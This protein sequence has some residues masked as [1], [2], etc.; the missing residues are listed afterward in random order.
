MTDLVLRYQRQVQQVHLA[1]K[2]LAPVTIVAAPFFG[3]CL[4]PI[5]RALAVAAVVPFGRPAYYYAVLIF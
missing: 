3:P 1:K 2:A 5:V 4:L